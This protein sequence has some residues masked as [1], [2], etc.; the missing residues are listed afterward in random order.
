MV[1]R[2]GVARRDA[3]SGVQTIAA[4]ERAGGGT[5]I[6]LF[7]A[8]CDPGGERLIFGFLPPEEFKRRIPERLNLDRIAFARSSG[9]KIRIH[10][11]EVRRAEDQAGFFVHDDAVRRSGPVMFDDRPEHVA[12][13]APAAGGVENPVRMVFRIVACR[14]D[15]VER[16]VA[17]VAV[18][19]VEAADHIRDRAV[20]FEAGELAD[21]RRGLRLELPF[22]EP[23]QRDQRVAPPVEEPGVAGD[24]RVFAV[25]LHD[26]PPHGRCEERGRIHLRRDAVV[27]AGRK[28]RA[29]GRG[30]GRAD[31]GGE[32]GAAAAGEVDLDIAGAEEIGLILEPVI[33]FGGQVHQI[34]P[35]RFAVEGAVFDFHLK[36]AVGRGEFKA[37]PGF[38]DRFREALFGTRVGFGQL[39]VDA[40]L[41]VGPQDQP[42]RGR[43]AEFARFALRIGGRPVEAEADRISFFGSG[44][45]DDEPHTAAL[46]G[47]DRED[48][49]RPVVRHGGERSDRTQVERLRITVDL[50]PAAQPREHRAAVDRIV[51]IH[52]CGENRFVLAC[53][54]A[55]GSAEEAHASEVVRREGEQLAVPDFRAGIRQADAAA[56]TGRQLQQVAV[57]PPDLP[58]RAE[59]ADLDSEVAAVRS[60]VFG[61][62]G[63]NDVAAVFRRQAAAGEHGPAVSENGQAEAVFALGQQDVAG[64]NHDMPR[65][66]AFGPVVG[67]WR[68][69]GFGKRRAETFGVG[70]HGGAGAGFSGGQP[71]ELDLDGHRHRLGALAA[72]P[73]RFVSGGSC[74]D[75]VVV[76]SDAECAARLKFVRKQ[77]AAAQE[78]DR[79]FGQQ[80]GAAVRRQVA[81]PAHAR[82]MIAVEVQ[83]RED[84]V[85]VRRSA[86]DGQHVAG[87]LLDQLDLRVGLKGGMVGE[88]RIELADQFDEVRFRSPV[89]RGVAVHVD[90]LGGVEFRSVR[91][92][93]RAVFG[94]H[95]GNHEPEL[96]IGFSRSG[97]PGVVMGFGE[98]DERP[99]GLAAAVD[100]RKI[101]RDLV[102]GIVL[103]EFGVSPVET[104]PAEQVLLHLQRTAESLQQK[105]RVR[106]F[107]ADLRDDVLPRLG[108]QHV[109]R[110]AA[111]AVYPPP[112]PEQENLGHEP[113]HLRLP[114]VQL[115]EV[116]PGDAPRAGTHEGSVRLAHK[117]IRMLHLQL[118]RPAGVIDR[119]IHEDAS[120]AGMHLIDEFA[121]LLHRRRFRVE[122]GQRRV[123]A[124]VVERG[125]RAAVPAHA[126]VLRRHRVNRQQLQNPAAEPVENMVELRGELPERSR[127]RND[128]V[129][130]GV[131]FFDRLRRRLRNRPCAVHAELPHEGRIHRVAA[132]AGGGF[133]LQPEVAG[134]GPLDAGAAGRHETALRFEDADL[135]QRQRE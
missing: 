63:E 5:E 125:E 88:Q 35:L 109:A 43:V 98:V 97:E 1:V 24:D 11:G 58:V 89:Q 54:F 110:V 22:D 132:D 90:L 61:Q 118:R 78:A 9:R 14:H 73:L 74:G 52:V 38:P 82:R 94:E 121:E 108:R 21:D 96:R 40:V 26:E 45:V 8:C 30:P 111:E 116:G 44:E 99:A 34:I 123:D 50:K 107:A 49:A 128:G 55:P 28:L 51:R 62:H 91:K 69:S 67:H 57:R 56:R 100:I 29:P 15:E 130:F 79:L 6:E 122:I 85:P 16:R 70:Q 104:G 126:P 20:F 131:E 84:H 119:D 47:R 134:V 76:E 59:A 86:A 32:H 68:Q 105:D 46:A 129:V 65:R 124:E 113:V 93:E 72:R 39:V 66:V 12:Q 80:L 31:F 36:R 4:E 81:F 41:E 87:P 114:V 48:P 25:A 135:D 133:D 75:P 103:E 27:A 120:A 101:A 127:G 33:T 19:V 95:C 64:R 92:A 83:Q 7:D 2:N 23:A 18:P 53:D 37:A 77:R 102:A 106:I 71:G 13:L 17:R 112:A 10:P 115:A 3:A 42:H 117:V 60:R